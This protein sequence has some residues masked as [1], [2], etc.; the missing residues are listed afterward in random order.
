MN[1]NSYFLDINSKYNYQHGSLRTIR[2][3]NTKTNITNKNNKYDPLK[4]DNRYLLYLY[5]YFLILFFI[6][7]TLLS[8]N[9][10]INL[11]QEFYLNA[12]LNINTPNI[13]TLDLHESKIIKNISINIENKEKNFFERFLFLFSSENT[14]Y[15]PSSYL[16]NS[17]IER[18]VFIDFEL[19]FNNNMS[20]VKPEIKYILPS[21]DQLM[22]MQNVERSNLNLSL[23]QQLDVILNELNIY[24]NQQIKFITI[25]SNINEGIE[26][27]YPSES[28]DT[29]QAYV[30]TIDHLLEDLN[31]RAN[32]LVSEL[33]KTDS[34]YTPPKF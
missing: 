33:Q 17:F 21:L 34:N 19:L 6:I 32:N 31:L 24:K 16:S 12:I 10:I 23:V 3:L 2:N 7:C 8:M 30:I 20:K 4:K 29:F 18:K 15:Y 25:I 5:F 9:S 26:N 14:N 1:F 11:I 22:Q 13:S 27:F 28:K